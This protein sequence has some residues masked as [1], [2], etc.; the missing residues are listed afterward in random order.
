MAAGEVPEQQPAG[1]AG[2]VGQAGTDRT[3]PVNPGGCIQRAVPISLHGFIPALQPAGGYRSQHPAKTSG[4]RQQVAT[5]I[6]EQSNLWVRH[7]PTR[8]IDEVAFLADGIGQPPDSGGHLAACAEQVSMNRL[9]SLRLD[10]REPP[11]LGELHRATAYPTRLGRIGRHANGLLTCLR[12]LRPQA[13]PQSLD[14]SA[15]A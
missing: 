12:R 14:V 4:G 3:L 5:G 13:T 15:A 8:P 9:P 11:A 7:Q 2:Q 10:E 6:P 1:R